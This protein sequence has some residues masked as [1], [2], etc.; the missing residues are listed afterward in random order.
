MKERKEEKKS[1]E[2]CLENS[3]VAMEASHSTTVLGR[4][5]I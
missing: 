4:H 1:K 5:G 2:W 3:L